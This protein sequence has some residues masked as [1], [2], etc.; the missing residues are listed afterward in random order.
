MLEEFDKMADP[1]SVASI[2][3]TVLADIIEGFSLPY[4]KWPNRSDVQGYVIYG[5]VKVNIT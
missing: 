4:P 1:G 5:R 3:H 2:L